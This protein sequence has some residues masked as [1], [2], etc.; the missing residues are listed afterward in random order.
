MSIHV[1]PPYRRAVRHNLD[2]PVVL[3]QVNVI[4]DEHGGLSVQVDAEPHRAGENLQRADLQRVV[5]NIAADL[6]SAVRVDV[7]EHDGTVFTDIITPPTNPSAAAEKQSAPTSPAGVLTRVGFAPH[8]P[9]AVAVV[10]A[11]Q[12]ADDSGTVRLALPPSLVATYGD[13]I[14]VVPETAATAEGAA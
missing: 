13:K 4:V 14:V 9:V 11:H 7:R 3:P 5:T 12:A 8:Q 1:S 6:G 10:V 2:V